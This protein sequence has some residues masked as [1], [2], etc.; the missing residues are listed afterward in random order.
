MYRKKR[1]SMFYYQSPFLRYRVL[2]YQ[3]VP[4]YWIRTEIPGSSNRFDEIYAGHFWTRTEH[5]GSFWNDVE[6]F[7]LLSN[8]LECSGNFK[9]VKFPASIYSTARASGKNKPSSW[10]ANRGLPHHTRCQFES[11][12]PKNTL[13]LFLRGIFCRLV[14]N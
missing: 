8:I 7:R 10:M 6:C 11:V 12:P 1:L 13:N 5:P 3:L 4:K 14:F 9:K 2:K